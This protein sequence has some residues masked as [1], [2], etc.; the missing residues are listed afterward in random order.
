MATQSSL[1]ANTVSIGRWLTPKDYGSDSLAYFQNKSVSDIRNPDFLAR[2]PNDPDVVV[3]RGLDRFLK[4]FYSSLL[5]DLGQP[6]STVIDNITL[7]QEWTDDAIE[8]W[9]DI[10][11]KLL[12]TGKGRHIASHLPSILNHTLA[13]KN[14]VRPSEALNESTIYAQYQCQV[15]RLKSKATLVMAV[16]LADLV[17]LRALWFVF[18]LITAAWLRQSDPHAMFCDGCVS[19]LM[20]EGLYKKDK[21]SAS[22]LDEKDSVIRSVTERRASLQGLVLS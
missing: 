8:D 3:P 12:P 10:S 17:F 21:W 6:Q 1:L 9:K 13:W 11:T 4:L 15:P 22:S 14:V 2:R 20:E 16:A 5:A 18:N 19:G 7:L